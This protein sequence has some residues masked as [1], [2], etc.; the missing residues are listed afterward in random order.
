MFE[1]SNIEDVAQSE[2]NEADVS[3]TAKPPETLEEAIGD[4]DTAEGQARRAEE[5]F[6][7]GRSDNPLSQLAEDV[8][9]LPPLP[10]AKEAKLGELCRVPKGQFDE[11]ELIEEGTGDLIG[12]LTGG[13]GQ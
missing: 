2:N 9:D 10:S 13:E 8:E 1:N 6:F 12:F 11:C 7:E 5:A 3:L 4:A